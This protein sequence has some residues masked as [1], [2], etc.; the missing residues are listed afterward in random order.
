ML[1]I[2]VKKISVAATSKRPQSPKQKETV[3]A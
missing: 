3:N 2:N 1:S